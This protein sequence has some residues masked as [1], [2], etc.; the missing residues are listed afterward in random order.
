M[1]TTVLNFYDGKIYF[2][3]HEKSDDVETLLFEKYDFSESNIQRMTTEKI[4]ME[5][6]Q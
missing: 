1:I 3:N 6:L 2:I 5:T 4:D